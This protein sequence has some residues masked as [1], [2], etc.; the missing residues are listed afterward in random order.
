[1][2]I[3]NDTQKFEEV[4]KK[5]APDNRLLRFWQL[6]GG[7][8]AQVTAL[9]VERANGQTTKWIVRQ[10]GEVD[11]NHN[12][13]VAADEFKLLQILK[14]ESVLVPEPLLL[15]QSAEIF[16]KPYL[17]MEYVAGKPDFAPIDLPRFIAQIALHLTKIHRLDSSKWDLSF[18][19]DKTQEI[20]SK[21]ANRPALLDDSLDE[22]RLRSALEKVWPLPECNRPSLL[23][24]DFW[25]GNIL[26]RNDQLVAVIDWEDAEFGDPLSDVANCRLELLWAF[27]LDAMNDFTNHY[28]SITSYDFTMLPYW[29]M[30]AALRPA[31]KLSTWGLDAATESKMR[32][33]HKWFVEQ[34]FDKAAR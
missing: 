16:S 34:A 27:G 1:M 25:P 29:D 5:I 18:L 8:S 24:G 10:H 4:I 12:P 3:K 20:A 33:R 21:L 9:E 15:D 32:E 23:H 19:P 14:S 6:E 30:V 7:V 31:S 11:F 2:T 17:V 22:P 13:D 28:K 26:W